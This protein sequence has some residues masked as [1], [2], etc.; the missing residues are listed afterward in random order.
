[1]TGSTVKMTGAAQALTRLLEGN[2]RYIASRMTNPNQTYERRKELVSKQNPFSV[3]L[4]CADS[5]VPPE[6]IF[7]QGLGDLFVIR[8]AGNVPGKTVLGSIE[9]AVLHLQVPLVLVLGHS[10]CGAVHATLSECIGTTEHLPHITIP[11][12]HAVDTIADESK[13]VANSVAKAHAKMT[14][15]K[16]KGAIPVFSDIMNAG[17]LKIIAAYYDLCTGVVELL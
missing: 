9:Y 13:R 6:L 3:I 17:K 1:M 14:A 8:V 16:L 5:R 4:G 10:G 15:T 7:D 11:I 2:K 12:Q